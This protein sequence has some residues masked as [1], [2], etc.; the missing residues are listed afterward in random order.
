[1][2]VISPYPGIFHIAGVLN[3]LNMTIKHY[4]CYESGSEF[5][6]RVR[7]LICNSLF[8]RKSHSQVSHKFHLIMNFIGLKCTLGPNLSSVQND[9]IRL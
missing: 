2:I 9:L 7:H 4:E 5:N 1:M 8:P 6:K 3:N